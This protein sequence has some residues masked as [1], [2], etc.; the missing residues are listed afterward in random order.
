M[1]QF[2][3]NL[4][5]PTMII[6]ES[7][8]PESVDFGDLRGKTVA[9]L[10]HCVMSVLAAESYSKNQISLH[11]QPVEPMETNTKYLRGKELIECAPRNLEV[12]FDM[13][14]GQKK[15]FGVK[16]DFS[17]V[18]LQSTGQHDLQRSEFVVT[19]DDEGETK[20][21][22][23]PKEFNVNMISHG[24]PAAKD[25]ELR[26]FDVDQGVV[27]N[28]KPAHL[29]GHKF[30]VV[31]EGK[32]NETIYVV[33]DVTCEDSNETILKKYLEQYPDVHASQ[34]NEFIYSI[35]ESMN[36]GGRFGSMKPGGMFD[37]IKT[38]RQTPTSDFTVDIVGLVGVS[39]LTTTGSDTI[40]TLKL[41]IQEA[42]DISVDRQLLIF[43]KGFMCQMRLQ[44][45][46][47][48]LRDY[49]IPAAA[50]IQVIVGHPDGNHIY[51]KTLTGKTIVLHYKSTYTVADIKAHI[52][53]KE[54]IPPDQMRLVSPEGRQELEDA[55]TLGDY[56]I[57][58]KALLHLILRLRGGMFHMTSSRE[59]FVQLGGEIPEV[60][61]PVRFGPGDDDAF[62]VTVP[63]LCKTIEFRTQVLEMQEEMEEDRRIAEMEAALAKAKQH[64]RSKHQKGHHHSDGSDGDSK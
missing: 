3:Y 60:Q 27:V 63:P 61:V 25:T 57:D 28:I 34:D 13:R 49:D 8:W 54:G 20:F 44:D 6:G 7:K 24:Q 47:L 14:T 29:S 26:W 31:V 52:Q 37:Y 64:R 21:Y 48:T 22:S 15:S 36:P 23:R 11:F 16:P 5:D 35:K 51:V 59:E 30:S 18:T 17:N 39:T 10:H 50:K 32:F 55:R 4:E 2:H 58:K 33:S 40:A 12:M 1:L 19:R 46:G 9:D 43:H 56:N 41:K 42:S 62:V 38:K 45:D 53:N